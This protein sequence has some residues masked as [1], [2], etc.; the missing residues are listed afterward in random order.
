MRKVT[1]VSGAVTLEAAPPAAE[2]VMASIMADVSETVASWIG[3]ALPD[4]RVGETISMWGFGCISQGLPVSQRVPQPMR[5]H[6]PSPSLLGISTRFVLSRFGASAYFYIMLFATVTGVSTAHGGSRC[7]S[8]R[9]RPVYAAHEVRRWLRLLPCHLTLLQFGSENC[10]LCS[11]RCGCGR[12][13]RPQACR[14]DA[15][16]PARCMV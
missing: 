11:T 13:R 14:Y 15:V 10:G 4:A 12:G 6:L 7:C 5:R 9:R 3:G 8:S 2:S 1:G 16:M